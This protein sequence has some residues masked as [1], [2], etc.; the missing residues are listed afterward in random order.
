MTVTSFDR[1]ETETIKKI[2]QDDTYKLELYS[3][4]TCD[5]SSDL[6]IKQTRGVV[7]NALDDSVVMRSFNYT[8]EFNEYQIDLIQP[9]LSDEMVSKSLIYDSHEGALLRAFYFMDKWF[10]ST[11]RKLDAFKSKWASTETYGEIFEKALIEELKVNQEL[12]SNFSD[13]TNLTSK[14]LSTLDKRYQY[15]FLVRNTEE[16][17]IVNYPPPTYT[18]YHVGTFIDGRVSMGIDCG[19]RKPTLYKFNNLNDVCSYVHENVNVKYTQGFIVFTPYNTQIKIVNKEYQEMVYVRGFEPSIKFRYLQIRMDKY[20]REKLY[21]LYPNMENTFDEIENTIYDVALYLYRSY[22]T[23]FIKR[24]HITLP[25]FEYKLMEICH[26]WH[27]EDRANNKV[28]VNKM[29]D[30]LNN[31]SP[32]NLN[33]MIRRFKMDSMQE[34]DKQ[35]VQHKARPRLIKN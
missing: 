22:V 20:I 19:I 9:L 3:Y 18:V 31:Q 4:T 14:F 30:V 27:M 7:V 5:V 24:E 17:R 16:N 26:S 12:S 10:L 6:S 33:H 32:S 21:L 28:S 1:T 2:D 35:P 29:I 13:F 11:H 25:K 15:M 34:A 8:P 23:R